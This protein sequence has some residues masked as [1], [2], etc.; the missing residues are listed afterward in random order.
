[1]FLV[2]Q[3]LQIG[4]GLL[5]WTLIGQGVLALLIGER[6]HGNA[7]YRL[8]QAVTWPLWRI[9]R[10]LSPIRLGEFQTGLVAFFLLL[11]LR[12]AVYMAFYAMGWIPSIEPAPD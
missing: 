11:A 1:M 7:V 5:M 2:F 8:F 10:I 12:F 4:I 3:I 9:T 6:R